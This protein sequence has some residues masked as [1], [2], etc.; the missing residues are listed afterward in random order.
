MLSVSD[1]VALEYENFGIQHLEGVTRRRVQ[2]NMR[3]ARRAAHE[4]PGPIT[5]AA[6]R[7]WYN[8]YV[9]MLHDGIDVC[10]AGYRWEPLTLTC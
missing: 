8:V 4:D 1:Y 2:A 6:W 9:Q 7:Q 3:A 5:E 10:P